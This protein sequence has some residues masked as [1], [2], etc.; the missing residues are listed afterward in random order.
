MKFVDIY[1]KG[2]PVHES[3]FGNNISAANRVETAIH[4]LAKTHNKKYRWKCKI[5]DIYFYLLNLDSEQ[6]DPCGRTFTN[7]TWKYHNGTYILPKELDKNFLKIKSD[8][9]K[10]KVKEFKYPDTGIEH[11]VIPTGKS[12]LG[13]LSPRDMWDIEFI[14]GSR[15]RRARYKIWHFCKRLFMSRIYWKIKVFFNF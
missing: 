3:I 15:D 7:F 4:L 13:H 10:L 14:V 11:Y 2:E 5:Q 12:D 9:W 6:Y 8:L 1:P